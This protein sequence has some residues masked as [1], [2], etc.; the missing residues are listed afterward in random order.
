MGSGLGQQKGVPVVRWEHVM[1]EPKSPGVVKRAA[2]VV[3]NVWVPVP[4]RAR[5]EELPEQIRDPGVRRR[6]FRLAPAAEV[7]VYLSSGSGT[8]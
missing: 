7:V 1:D 4:G 5:A 8:E 3:A 6:N 2:V